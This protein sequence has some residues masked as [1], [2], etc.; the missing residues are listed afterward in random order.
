MAQADGI[1]E[2][3]NSFPV[4]SAACM[5]DVHVGDND[6]IPVKDKADF[7]NLAPKNLPGTQHNTITAVH[8]RLISILGGCSDLSSYRKENAKNGTDLFLQTNKKE[9]CN[10]QVYSLIT[11]I[12]FIG[13]AVLGIGAA[14]AAFALGGRGVAD[15]D[16]VVL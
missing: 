6:D 3:S 15:D 11:V 13:A 14:S 5:V 2:N 1:P 8:I 12:P 9:L 4:V 10:A 7:H 16:Y